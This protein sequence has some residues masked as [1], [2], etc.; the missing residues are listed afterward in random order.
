[1]FEDLATLTTTD[2]LE[3]AAE[4]RAEIN[5]LEAR[6]LAHAQIFADR[7]HPDSCPPRPGRRGTDG[8][9]R[10]VVLGGDGCPEIAEFAPAEFG[11]VLGM[12]TYAAAAYIGQAQALQHRFPRIWA[13]VQAGTATPWRARKIATACHDLSQETAATIDKRLARC[14]DTVTPQRLE[15]I[16]T[17]AQAHAD[18][19]TARA[20][21]QQ[22]KR[23]RGVHLGRSDEHGNKTV[24]IRTGSGH[25]IRFNATITSIADALK[26]FGDTR[27]VQSRRAEAV[28]IIADSPYTQ[29][30]LTQAQQHLHTNPPLTP[31]AD[32]EAATTDTP[33]TIHTTDDEPLTDRTSHTE[34]SQYDETARFDEPGPHDEADRDAPH[35]SASDDPD[36]L[37]NPGPTPV[38]SFDP[39]LCF[40]PDDGEP[41]DPAAQRALHARLA[42]IKHDAHTNPTANGGRLR[43][44]KTEIYVH[45]TDRTL[46]TGAGVL[47]AET[48][49]PL[50]A[51]Q[52]AELVGHGPYVVKPVIDLNEAISVDAYE[53]PDRIRER[54]KLTHPVELFP[55]G[56]RET[57]PGMD[58]DHIQPYDPLGP[59][60]QTNTTNLAPLG[61][62]SHRVKTH[63]HGWSVHRIDPKTLEWTTPHGFTFHV[64]PT[65]TRRVISPHPDCPT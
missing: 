53:T 39:G 20:K 58:L 7:N 55:Y 27:S 9:E 2:L 11:A 1:M 42:Q 33:P 61:R 4:H 21:A 22:K 25:A 10:G 19:E 34:P 45:L 35:P 31:A 32:H 6:L 62:L 54:V 51:D 30:L 40:E 49:G 28:G 36:P 14:V 26:I 57:H 50:L 43:P 18:P 63:A 17:A 48:I 56:T 12:S 65:G 47:R 41:M 8:R 59:P 52:L 44:G 37:D 60:G 38:E 23:E 16:V 64:D 29:E 5:R 46:A 15:N 13:K 3:S 24:Y